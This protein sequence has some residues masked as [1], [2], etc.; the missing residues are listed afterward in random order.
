MNVMPRSIPNVP[1]SN[2]ITPSHKFKSV[3]S[4]NFTNGKQKCVGVSFLIAKLMV[5]DGLTPM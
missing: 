2:P 5:S 3:K 1:I 4:T